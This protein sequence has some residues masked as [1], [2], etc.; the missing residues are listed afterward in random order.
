[1]NGLK[2]LEMPEQFVESIERSLL[3]RLGGRSSSA[4]GSSSASSF[5][6]C[7]PLQKG[8]EMKEKYFQEIINLCGGNSS[9]ET[10]SFGISRIIRSMGNGDL[11]WEELPEEV[12]TA[13]FKAIGH[14][15]SFLFDAKEISN[16]VFG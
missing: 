5:L 4:I 3:H 7:Y 13:C 10:G 8:K 2:C 6:L 11:K 1:M 16:V 12:K 14:F 9:P 15:S